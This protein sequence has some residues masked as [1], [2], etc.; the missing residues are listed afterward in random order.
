MFLRSASF[1]ERRKE[2]FVHRKEQRKFGDIFAS[3]RALHAQSI[4][5]RAVQV[6]AIDSTDR[7]SHTAKQSEK[8]MQ[9]SAPHYGSGKKFKLS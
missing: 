7:N 8:R 1:I 4:N 9:R 5:V 6:G 3:Y 2:P